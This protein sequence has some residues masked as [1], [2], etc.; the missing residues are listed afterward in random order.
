MSASHFFSNDYFQARNKFV[1]TINELKDLGNQVRHD[2]LI[3][4]CKGPN[5]EDLSIDIAT[6][7]SIDSDNLIL[8]SSGIHGVEGFAGSAIQLSVL[9]QLKGESPI[10]DYCLVFIHIINPYGM[11]W[12]RRVNEKNVDLNRNFLKVHQG[13][14][15]GYE[16]INLFV[17][18]QTI[19]SK[20][21]FMFWLEGVNLILKY[22]FTNVK[23]WIAQ[24]QYT[25]PMSLQYGGNKLEQGPELILDWLKN[26][27]IKTKNI[28]AIDLHTGLGPSGYDTILIQ[29]DIKEKDYQTLQ[30]MFGSHLT[31]LDPTKGVGYRVTGDIHSGFVSFLPNFNWL[32]ITQEF[33]TFNPVK[34]FKSLRAEN[35]WTQYNKNCDKIYLKRHWSRRNLL[36]IFNPKSIKWQKRLLD[37]G[38]KV[39]FNAI[40]HINFNIK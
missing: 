16:K 12:H 29:E 19:P 10:T 17:N 5:Q 28:F 14:P 33:G 21:D 34:V 37:R 15:E 20:I 40:D 23:Q 7:G 3:L 22:G 11:V 36:R 2:E 32:C 24:G 30:S 25:R 1:K 31:Q 8:Y 4:D 6:I 13:E 18:P 35:K 38:N 39:F 9:E 26:N 27:L